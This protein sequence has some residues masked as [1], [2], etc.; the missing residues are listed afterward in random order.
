MK[1]AISAVMHRGDVRFFVESGAADF[2]FKTNATA[3]GIQHHR[4]TLAD[5][6]YNKNVDNKYVE[7][8]R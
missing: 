4:N 2:M 6:F 8:I 7:D 5:D 3:F 1:K